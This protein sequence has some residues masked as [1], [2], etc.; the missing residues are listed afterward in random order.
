MRASKSNLTALPTSLSPPWHCSLT[1][2]G[3]P[4]WPLPRTGR[5][6]WRSTR[7][8]RPCAPRPRA[9]RVPPHSPRRTRRPRRRAQRA[10]GRAGSRRVRLRARFWWP[11]F[12]FGVRRR[13][14]EH[15]ARRSIL[16]PCVLH[17]RCRRPA[18]RHFHLELCLGGSHLHSRYVVACRPVRLRRI[19]R[20]QVI[21]ELAALRQAERSRRCYPSK[22]KR[23][24]KTC[25]APGGPLS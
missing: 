22:E 9:R 17:W 13:P 25:G 4:W 19:Q 20:G 1:A 23:L 6:R 8:A 5:R 15:L 3:R 24:P 7:W 11:G 16:E 14:G 2:G 10:P 21:D 18:D 12:E